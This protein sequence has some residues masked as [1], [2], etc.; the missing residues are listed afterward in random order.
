VPI[1]DR[2]AIANNNK[3]DLFIS[4][5]RQRFAAGS[6]RPERRSTRGVRKERRPP[7]PRRS[8]AAC[9]RS[10]GGTREIDLVRWDLAQTQHVDQ[11]TTFAGLLERLLQERVPMAP[12]PCDRA[13]LRVLES[14]NMPAVLVEMGYLTNAEQEKLLTGDA[15]QGAF[16]QALL[17]RGDPVPRRGDRRRRR[18]VNRGGA[19]AIG[20]IVAVAVLLVWALFVA[21]PSA[22]VRPERQTATPTRRQP[23]PR[24]PGRKI[25]AR[26]FY[27]ADDGVHLVRQERD[28]PYGEGTLEQ[29]REIIAA[30]VAPRRAA[31]VRHPAGTT[32][33]ALFLTEAAK[34]TSMSAA[35]SLAASGGTIDE[36]LTVYTIVDALTDNLP[37]VTAV[38]LL[39][40]GKEV[41][42]LAGH[43]DLRAP[44][45]KNLS[46]G[47]VDRIMRSDQRAPNEL[48]ETT[49]TPELPDPRRRIGPH[50]GRHTKVICT[51]SVEDRVPPF[52]R[53]TGKGWVTAEYGMLPRAT[54]TRTQREARR[55]GR[56]P[57]AG[58]SAPDRPIAALGRRTCRAR[59]ADDLDR[60]RRD[61]GRRRH[62]DR[63]DH[64]RVRRARPRARDAAR[65]RRHP[66]DSAARLRR[67]HSVGIVDGEPLLDLAYDDDSRAEVDMN[68]VKT[69]DGRFIEV[70]GTRRRC[71]RPRRADDAARPA[72][73]R[74]RAARRKTARIVGHLVK[75]RRKATAE[76]A[77]AAD[78]L[79]H[80][81]TNQS[82]I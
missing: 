26:L 19:L 64:R 8:A 28:V 65:A 13:P 74:H 32:V 36:L 45:A 20:G 70:Q 30:Q 51:A 55:Q 17:R 35:R 67:R 31:R 9:P 47:T 80:E 48:R 40:D 50:R 7:P 59:R 12:Q 24:L 1:D 3:A 49:I 22:D 46:M 14:A 75:S 53:N 37:G 69:G 2:T 68:I 33:R 39:V 61:P 66:H 10:G 54:S 56:R 16:V 62:A 71:L 27:V 81:S 21:L 5:P 11:S 23:R 57:H 18:T 73:L 58:D 42:T 82:E 63:V 79:I 29:A 77:E 44:L 6:P 38:Q 78:Q 76:N 25:K 72:R 34:R 4:L 52:L 60:L 41:D 43:V 15:F